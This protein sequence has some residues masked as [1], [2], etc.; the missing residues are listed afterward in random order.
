M[1]NQVAAILKGEDYQHLYAWQFVLELLM[2]KRRVRRVTIE[3]TLAGSMDDVIVQYE[4]DASFPNKFY[5]VKYHVDQKDVYS[6]D[7]LIR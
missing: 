4:I 5:Q 2:P 7:F 3:D 1:A 6:A